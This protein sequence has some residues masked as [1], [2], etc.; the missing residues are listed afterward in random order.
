MGH[1][2]FRVHVAGSKIV[3]GS[4]VLTLAARP[5]DTASSSI[6]KLRMREDSGF[7]E[8]LCCNDRESTSEPVRELSSWQ[9]GTHHTVEPGPGTSSRRVA[10]GYVSAGRVSVAQPWRLNSHGVRISST[11]QYLATS[12]DTTKVAWLSKYVVYKPAVSSSASCLPPRLVAKVLVLGNSVQSGQ[13]P[14]K[15]G[16]QS[17]LTHVSVSSRLRLRC[18]AVLD[19]NKK[20]FRFWNSPAVGGG[21]DQS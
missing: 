19:R 21:L 15:E 18:L 7:D 14:P 5:V 16:C 13:L 10:R 17:H 1:K 8:S 3:G 4:S 20:Y 12:L 11:V 6:L 9:S 2:P